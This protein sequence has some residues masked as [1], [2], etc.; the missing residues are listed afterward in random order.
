MYPNGEFAL[1][2]KNLLMEHDTRYELKVL[3]F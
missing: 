3:Y 2:G 1:L